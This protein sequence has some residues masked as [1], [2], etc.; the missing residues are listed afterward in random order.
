[1]FGRVFERAGSHLSRWARDEA[2]NT[3][4]EWVLLVGGLV[5]LSVVVMLS[6]GGG[7]EE[8]ATRTDD[9]LSARDVT[10]TY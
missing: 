9:E 4:V 5:G 8:L 2:G 1:M 3:T 7:V 6:I 10:S